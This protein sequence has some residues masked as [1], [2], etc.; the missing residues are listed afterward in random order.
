M[1]KEAQTRKAIKKALRAHTPH[2]RI[3][4]DVELMVYL[5]LLVFLETIAEEAVREAQRRE[6]TE[7]VPRHLHP[8]LNVCRIFALSRL[9][10]NVLCRKSY[11]HIAAETMKKGDQTTAEVDSDT[12]QQHWIV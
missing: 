7:I 2:K 5:D 1:P 3:A 10:L 8:I 6:A 12:V 4:A 9:F 11:G